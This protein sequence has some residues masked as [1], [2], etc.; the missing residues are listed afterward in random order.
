MFGGRLVVP[1]ASWPSSETGL[2]VLRAGRG[3][4]TT[5]GGGGQGLVPPT[6][7]PSM[8]TWPQLA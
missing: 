7:L 8:G 6:L 1:S 2:A 4:D 5:R 3:V